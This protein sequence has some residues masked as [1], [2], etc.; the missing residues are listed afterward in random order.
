MLLESDK[1][2]TA[3]DVSARRSGGLLLV[4][5]SHIKGL[6]GNERA[7]EREEEGTRQREMCVPPADKCMEMK[8]VAIDLIEI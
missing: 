7:S 1:R 8:E 5:I 6:A 2:D 3:A 4:F